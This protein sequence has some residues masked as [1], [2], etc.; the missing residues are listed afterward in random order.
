[1][2]FSREL[3]KSFYNID[4]LTNYMKT[5]YNAFVFDSLEDAL[6]FYDFPNKNQDVLSFS[7]NTINSKNYKC[8]AISNPAF[9]KTKSNFPELILVEYYNDK[10]IKQ[11]APND[12]FVDFDKIHLFLPFGKELYFDKSLKEEFK[13]K[14]SEITNK[15]NNFNKND[16]ILFVEKYYN[17]KKIEKNENCVCFVISGK[18][19]YVNDKEKQILLEMTFSNDCLIGLKYSSPLFK[20][21][22]QLFSLIDTKSILNNIS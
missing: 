2:K 19:N 4:D 16:I 17:T 15:T 12:N 20:N 9:M 3:N 5:Y 21:S 14:L 11:I 6:S 8:Y 10:S 18:E 7:E 13:N 1:M 22:N